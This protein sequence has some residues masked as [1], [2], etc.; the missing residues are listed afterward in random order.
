M[1]KTIL[2]VIFTLL[3]V[4]NQNLSANETNGIKVILTFQTKVDTK[5]EFLDFLN[6]NIPNVRAFEGCSS[7][8]LYFNDSTNEMII[9][10]N[11]KS[12][13]H[14]SNY[15]KFISENGVMKKLASY[16][17]NKPT[18]KYYDILDI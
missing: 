6:K 16:L 1:R 14:H 5:K 10:E 11:W 8:K 7:V 3:T 18:I 13:E 12:N 17:Q 4:L 2:A 9:T 15:I